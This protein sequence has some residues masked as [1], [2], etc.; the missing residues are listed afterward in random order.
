MV[1]FLS[2]VFVCLTYLFMSL[3]YLIKK[4]SLIFVFS[5]VALVTNAIHYSL[6][7]AWAG[8]GVVCVAI[9]RN[10]LFI[11][12]SK[13]KSLDK[14]VVDDWVILTFLF[15]V[16]GVV[17]IFT[18]ESY[19]SL[20]TIFASAVYMIS[21]WQKNITV[22]RILGIVSSAL[23]LVYMIY[24]HSILGIVLES[25]ALVVAICSFIVRLRKTQNMEKN[26]EIQLN[27]VNL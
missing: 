10:I 7:G 23:S 2:Q 1:Y 18:Y 22:Y 11:I 27:N 14:T 13:I 5:F 24:I 16:L 15:I 3:T 21:L 4:R 20:F 9:L 19:F 8:L 25:I 6:L 12:Q 17:S 26:S